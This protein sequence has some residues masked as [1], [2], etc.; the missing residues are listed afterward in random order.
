[1]N[2]F[3]G[4]LDSTMLFVFRYRTF[5]SRSW[6]ICLEIMWHFNCTLVSST[7][8]HVTSDVTRTNV[9][10]P[11]PFNW[12]FQVAKVQVGRI[13]TQATIYGLLGALKEIV[14]FFFFFLSSTCNWN[15]TGASER[16]SSYGAPSTEILP[17]ARIY[18]DLS[19]FSVLFPDTRKRRDVYWS[20]GMPNA[21]S[22]SRFQTDM[23]LQAHVL[24]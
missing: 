4:L 16:T 13:L 23:F 15:E 21:L 1:M 6:C 18:N 24:H 8:L 14:S 5:S 3:A 10:P 9:R 11:P 2:T 17:F 19:E 7:S 22:A 12:E 20:C